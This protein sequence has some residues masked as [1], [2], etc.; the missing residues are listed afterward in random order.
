MISLSTPYIKKECHQFLS[1]C[2][3]KL[4]WDPQKD[5]D[6]LLRGDSTSFSFRSF[7]FKSIP[8]NPRSIPDPSRTTLRIAN[9]LAIIETLIYLGTAVLGYL[10]GTN[11]LPSALQ[12]LKGRVHPH[13]LTATGI[14]GLTISFFYLLYERPLE[15]SGYDS[16]CD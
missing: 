5:D 7:S 1:D 6:D 13:A 4:T 9:S 12:F 3:H 14:T 15:A 16:D 10:V 8:P 2:W 11:A